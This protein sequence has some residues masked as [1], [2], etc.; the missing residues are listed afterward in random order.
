MMK[1][2]IIITL[3]GLCFV[4]QLYSSECYR[5]KNDSE[6]RLDSCRKYI[7]Y[8]F[9]FANLIDIYIAEGDTICDVSILDGKGNC[10][11][12]TCPKPSILKWAFED[13][14]NEITKSPIIVDNNYNPYYYKLSILEDS[15]QTIISSSTL[16]IDYSDDVKNKIEEL[17]AF[18]VRLWYSDFVKR[19]SSAP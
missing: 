1:Y 10:V 8:E 12:T 7:C 14:A 5:G 2:F 3:F 9:G 6:L 15:S 11:S 16:L 19:N 18:I 13:I 17:K 4:N